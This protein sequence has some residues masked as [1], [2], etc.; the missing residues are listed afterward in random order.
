MYSEVA[1]EK[2]RVGYS[3]IY[4]VPCA[5]VKLVPNLG[6]GLAGLDLRNAFLPVLQN[7]SDTKKL[8]HP[9]RHQRLFTK[10]PIMDF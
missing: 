3:E 4:K 10:T 2:R 5:L 9:D 7:Q 6:P 1:L 8:I